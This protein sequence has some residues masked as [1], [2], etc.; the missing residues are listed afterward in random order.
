MKIPYSFSLSATI[1]GAFI[2]AGFVSGQELWQ[3]F[4]RYGYFGIA[5][6]LISILGI[7]VLSFLI[8]RYAMIKGASTFIS[9]I[10]PSESKISK[11]LLLLLEAVFYFCLHL[12]MTAGARSLM[13]EYFKLD[14]TVS[15]I[16]FVSVVAVISLTGVKKIISFFIP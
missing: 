7:V 8:M 15:A 5:G 3:F 14:I 2:G 13:N 1:A 10:T 11:I 9:V 6:L 16:I 4:G 12:I